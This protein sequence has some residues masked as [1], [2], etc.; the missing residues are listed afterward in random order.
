MK[1]SFHILMLEDSKLDAEL[2]TARLRKAELPLEFTLTRDRREF[3]ESLMA[4]PYD[5]ILADYSLPDF[6]GTAALALAR[7]KLPHTPFIFI[8]GRVGEEVAIDTLQ[9]GATDYVL[10]HRL[11]RLVP[12]VMRALKEQQEHHTRMQA[13][14]RFRESESRFRHVI[15]AVPQMIWVSRRDGTLLYSNQVW[16]DNVIDD[17]HDWTSP[18]LFH[19]ADYADFATAWQAAL[20]DEAPFSLEARLLRRSDRSY[21]W[22]LL[23]V[24]PMAPEPEAGPDAEPNWLG[25]ATDIQDRKLNEEALRTAE[26]L[27][28]TGRMAAAIAHEINNP[29]ESLTNLLFLVRLESSANPRALAFLDMTDNELERI[30]SITKQTLQFYRDPSMPVS[31]NA[32]EILDE[33][34]RLFAT[35]M[36]GKNINFSLSVEPGI[37]FQ[38]IKGEIRQVLINLI[39]NAIDAVG[40][41]GIIGV[42]S[43][44]GS[45]D[46]PTVKIEVHDN[47][48]GITAEQSLRLFQPF[49]STKGVHGTGLGLWVSRGIVEKHGGT[50]EL[51]TT[52]DDANSRTTATIILPLEAPSE[53]AHQTEQQAA[54]PIH[55]KPA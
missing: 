42:E 40:Q 6:D 24:S 14:A 5:L 15:D 16:K 31:I 35:R 19:P 30:S 43:S 13:E 20:R 27:S 23:R 37:T 11:E 45:G 29:L 49:F 32:G 55:T 38:A 50:L 3:E 48:S 46:H 33:V 21:R 9:R 28:V 25:T 51:A 22:H 17:L 18:D 8:S 52:G 41:H 2:V 7:A 10:K 12:A 4:Q 54:Q 1:K 34:H 47:G 36:R 44:A 53:L 39:G 26:K